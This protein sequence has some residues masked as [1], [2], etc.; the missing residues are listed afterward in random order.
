MRNLFRYLRDNLGSMILALLLSFAVWIAATLQA[1][2]FVTELLS[3]VPID[4]RDQPPDTVLFEPVIEVVN[5]QVRAP[6]SVMRELGTVDFDA[7]MNLS[8]VVPGMPSVVPVQVTTAN[9]SIRIQSIDPV[10]Q[11]VHLEALKTIT[12]SVDLKMEGKV[13]TGFQAAPPTISPGVVSVYGPTPYLSDVVSVSAL[14]NIE[15]V[16][17]NV[18]QQVLVTPRNAN[19]RLAPNVQ[20]TPDQVQVEVRVRKRVGFK[21]DVEVVPDLRV[22][23]AQGYRLGSV[24]VQPSVV[25]LKGPPSVLEQLP[26]FVKTLPISVTGATQD[27]LEHTPI[28]VPASVVVVDSS[29]VTVTV[30]ILPIES[31]KTMT[32]V[33][34]LQGV[35]AD[36]IASPSPDVV[37]V[38]LEG[39]DTVL[40]ELVPGDVQILL[41]LYDYPVGTHRIEPVVLAP[42]NVVVVSVI[43]ETIEVAIGKKPEPVVLTDTI[44]LDD[45]PSP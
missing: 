33:V 27:L 11:I 1:D 10:E 36:L 19:G 24:E 12:L 16:K 34:E 45:Q 15:G 35:P 32:V 18:T 25:T 44:P 39:P 17:E 14:V 3:N 30:Q 7:S 22:S 5:V 38:I 37:D 21:P 29:V 31:S 2:P 9:E 6:D 23:T 8:G 13:P 43:P 42:G 20:W 40:S 26:G 4:L 41:N 28:T